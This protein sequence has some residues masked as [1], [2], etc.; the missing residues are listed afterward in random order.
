[1]PFDK[2]IRLETISKDNWY[3]CSRLR[4]KPEQ[5]PF[6]A[7]NLLC[8]AEMQFYP[9]WRAYAIY[10]QE[11]MVGFALVEH[12]EEAN[13]WWISQL[14]ITAEQ[15]GKGYGKAAAREL[16]RLMWEVGCQEIFIGYADQN[17]AAHALYSSLG[18][19]DTGLDEEGDRVAH[20]KRPL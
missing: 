8:I 17:S 7:S 19:V 14:M 1:M 3:E 6:V 12:D 5:E 4:V 15:Q 11:Q 2:T 20:L 13:E 9:G 10:H 18:F 16:I